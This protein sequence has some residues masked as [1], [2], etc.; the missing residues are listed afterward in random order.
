[1]ERLLVGE[2][3]FG[4]RVLE[5]AI[6]P[7]F[8]DIF[9]RYQSAIYGYILNMVGNV[10]QAQDLTQDTF[11]KAYKALPGTQDLVLPAWL[12]RIATNT[13]LDAL[14]HRRR[15]TWLPFGPGED[16]A[17]PD[18]EPDLPTSLAEGESMRLALARLTPPQRACLLMRARDG[19]SIDEIAQAMSM[20]KGNVKITLYRAKERFR[21][22][23]DDLEKLSVP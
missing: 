17:I 23:Y 6:R 22:V 7:S 12:Y 16:E 8:D 14:R 9:A 19:L 4:S 21:A 11:I 18:S 5:E 3:A 15:L 10:E 2:Q 1:M 20:S 13:A